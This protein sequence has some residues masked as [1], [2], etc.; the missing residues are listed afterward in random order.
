[1]ISCFKTHR[2]LRSTRFRVLHRYYEAIRL[3]LWHRALVVAFLGPTV[4][5]PEEISWGKDE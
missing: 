2:P 4:S 5:G 1:V 3:V